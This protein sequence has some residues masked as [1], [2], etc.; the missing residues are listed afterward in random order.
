MRVDCRRSI[1]GASAVGAMGVLLILWASVSFVV[2]VREQVGHRCERYKLALGRAWL[3][4]SYCRGCDQ[5][6]DYG[7]YLYKYWSSGRGNCDPNL[8]ELFSGGR[9]GR[10]LAVATGSW[11]RL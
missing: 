9:D 1:V 11:R 2:H 10:P 7:S 6:S 4:V 8:F 3:G 5:D